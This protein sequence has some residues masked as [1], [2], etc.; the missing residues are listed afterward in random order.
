[1]LSKISPIMLTSPAQKISFARPLLP[2]MFHVLGSWFCNSAIMKLDWECWASCVGV[3][4]GMRMDSRTRSGSDLRTTAFLTRGVW[5]TPCLA[6]LW[7]QPSWP[8]RLCLHA[9]EHDEETDFLVGPNQ[10]P[11]SQGMERY[12]ES[13]WTPLTRKHKSIDCRIQKHFNK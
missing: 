11:H 12:M 5:E 10:T 7:S 6:P 13:W 4:V 3:G 2:M 8:L 1:M 9:W